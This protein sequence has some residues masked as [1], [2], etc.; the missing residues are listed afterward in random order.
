MT[1]ARRP[2]TGLEASAPTTMV[3]ALMEAKPSMCAPSWI[4]TTSS[5]A[6][7]WEAWGSELQQRC[8]WRFHR[9]RRFVGR[10]FGKSV[11]GCDGEGKEACQM[12]VSTFSLS[13]RTS[14]MKRA[15]SGEVGT[16]AMGEKCA[17]ALLTEMEVGNAM[18]AKGIAATRRA[19]G[20]HTHRGQLENV[21]L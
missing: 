12:S 10:R 7:T 15:L 20:A 19:H 11:C 3:S 6:R 18:P 2:V 21:S 9:M 13:F 17:T 1:S 8:K 4:F 5:L 16:Y 14:E